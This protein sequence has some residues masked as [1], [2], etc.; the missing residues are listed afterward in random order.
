MDDGLPVRFNVCVI[1]YPF[2]FSFFVKAV[3]IDVE[4][5]ICFYRILSLSFSLSLSLSLFL[6][7]SF[8]RWEG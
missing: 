2:V 3:C 4:Y 6:S 8:L 5:M 7:R 1:L